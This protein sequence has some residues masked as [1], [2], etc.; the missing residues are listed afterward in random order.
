MDWVAVQPVRDLALEGEVEVH[1]LSQEVHVLLFVESELHG[2]TGVLGGEVDVY[3]S[4]L[5]LVAFFQDVLF[6]LLKDVRAIIVDIVRCA[7]PLKV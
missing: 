7:L 4:F 3:R 2:L 6:E 5:R 1:L